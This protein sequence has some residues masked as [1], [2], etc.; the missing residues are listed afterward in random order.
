MVGVR[1]RRSFEPAFF[2]GVGASGK[3]KLGTATLLHNTTGVGAA[4]RVVRATKR[5]EGKPM[6]AVGSNFLLYT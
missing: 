3:S 5:G 2:W 1:I 4:K 6:C